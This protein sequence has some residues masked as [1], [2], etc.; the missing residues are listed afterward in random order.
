MAKAKKSEIVEGG[1]VDKELKQM[2]AKEIAELVVEET[3]DQ[4]PGPSEDTPSPEPVMTS[5]F[6]LAAA[7]AKNLGPD[8]FGSDY[9]LPPHAVSFV[10][11]GGEDIEYPYTITIN[12][13]NEMTMDFHIGAAIRAGQA[14]EPYDGLEI[15]LHALGPRAIR[16]VPGDNKYTVNLTYIFRV[17]PI[18]ETKEA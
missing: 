10:A 2:V 4:V 9:I 7:I 12:A 1:I 14:L 16:K 3:R 15:L 8:F 13:P 5:Y 18:R 17:R 6:D 11:E